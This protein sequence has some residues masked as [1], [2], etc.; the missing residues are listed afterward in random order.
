MCPICIT[1]TALVAAG[2]TSGVGVLGFLA[3]KVRALG[4]QRRELNGSGAE[5]VSTGRKEGGHVVPTVRAALRTRD[6]S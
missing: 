4:R 2:T 6:C 1:T 3:E 5:P